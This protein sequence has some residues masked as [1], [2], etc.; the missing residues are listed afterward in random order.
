[1]DGFETIL[2]L[3][4]NGKIMYFLYGNQKKS[5]KIPN[6]NADCVIIKLEV[7]YAPGR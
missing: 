5:E 3:D 7:N 6:L 2:K 4:E 1:M